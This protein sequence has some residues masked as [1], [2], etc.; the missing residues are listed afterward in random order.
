M[1]GRQ[2]L[3]DR[4]FLLGGISPPFLD[5]QIGSAAGDCTVHGSCFPLT[6]LSRALSRHSS[7]RPTLEH[8]TVTR[9]QT[10]GDSHGDINIHPEP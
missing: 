8:S 9:F 3:Q 1:I 7:P 6:W 4:T 5:S 2:N 10:D